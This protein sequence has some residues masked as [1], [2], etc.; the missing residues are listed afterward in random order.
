MN[1]GMITCTY[2]MR[3]YDYK[4]P[5]PFQWGDMEDK[6]R[7]EFKKDD[8]LELVKEIKSVGFNSL[9]IW[10]PMYSFEVY[11]PDD[12]KDMAVELN[13]L[14]FSSLAY[15]IGGWRKKDIPRI[16]KAYAFAKAM[17]CKVVTGC[18]QKDDA[19]VILDEVE[20]CGIKYGLLYAIENHPEPSIEKPEDV[21]R[22]TE[23]YKT[24]GANL[25]TGIYN[26]MGYD[27]LKAAD[28]LKEKVYHVHFKDSPKGG[29]GCLP[30]GD[31]DTPV[32]ELLKKFKEWDYPYMVSVE[33]EYPTDPKPGLYKS[34]GFI[35]GVL[36]CIK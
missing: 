11:T 16:E 27:V 17:G 7:Q 9:E 5:E 18:I 2:Y 25:D 31:S 22:L 19:Q 21:D 35:N 32:A 36:A 33:Y 30:L 3:I 13:N 28:L 14:G 12:A 6:Y 26:M 29:D 1:I 4:R 24:V 10:A 15:C 8:F 23:P 34:M 20:R